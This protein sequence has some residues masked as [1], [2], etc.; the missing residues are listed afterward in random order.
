MSA[1]STTDGDEINVRRSV[2]GI[3]SDHI[4]SVSMNRFGA[5]STVRDAEVV[6]CDLIADKKDT[7]MKEWGRNDIHVLP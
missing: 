6:G 7:G 3:S 4:P 2:L 1:C 5:D